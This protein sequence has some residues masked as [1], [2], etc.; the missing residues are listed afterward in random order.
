MGSR[1]NIRVLIIGLLGILFTFQTALAQ[2][3]KFG[4]GFFI[5]IF[6]HSG[7]AMTV[8]NGNKQSGIQLSQSVFTHG[9]NQQFAV[10]DLHQGNKYRIVARHS[11]LLLTHDNGRITQAPANGTSNQKFFIYG[12]N[13]T[14]YTIQCADGSKKYLQINERTLNDGDPVTTAL[15]KQKFKIEIEESHSSEKTLNES[16]NKGYYSLIPHHSS[17]K[18]EIPN[19]SKSR[20]IQVVQQNNTFNINQQFI[21]IDLHDGKNSYKIQVRHSKMYLTNEYGRITQQPSWGNNEQKFKISSVGEGLYTIQSLVDFSYFDVINGSKDNGAVLNCKAFNGDNNQKFKIKFEEKFTVRKSGTNA[22]TS[23]SGKEA[24]ID[25]SSKYFVFL[26]SELTRKLINWDKKITLSKESKYYAYSNKEINERYYLGGASVNWYAEYVTKEKKDIYIRDKSNDWFWTC[27]DNKLVLKPKNDNLDQKFNITILKSLRYR[28]RNAGY[29][30]LIQVAGKD[31]FAT[32]ELNEETN[33]QEFFFQKRDA[34]QKQEF[35]LGIVGGR[36][37]KERA[38]WSDKKYVIFSKFHNQNIDVTGD[39]VVRKKVTNYES[40][41]WSFKYINKFEDKVYIMHQSSKKY[42][43]TTKDGKNLILKPDIGS[44]RQHFTLRKQEDGSFKF[45][46]KNSVIQTGYDK[47]GSWV[48]T[49]KPSEGKTWNTFLIRDDYIQFVPEKDT[50]VGPIFSA[51][52][53][54]VDVGE[55][56]RIVMN[57]KDKPQDKDNWYFIRTSEAD[58]GAG[59]GQGS[60]RIMKVTTNQFLTYTP[61]KLLLSDPAK[62]KEWSGSGRVDITRTGTGRYTIKIYTGGINPKA[63][64]HGEVI[65]HKGIPYH[66]KIPA[67]CTPKPLWKN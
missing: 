46:T 4:S 64:V 65:N 26:N 43:T 34:S 28:E 57:C 29:N 18:L 67:L 59:P 40:Q 21:F 22:S 45:Y 58:K 27:V 53:C 9:Y 12:D 36:K 30:C 10:I 51:N 17:K 1:F 56:N 42:L 23:L 54:F 8:P 5:I 20:G 55:K 60:F 14:G 52:G 3:S 33:K 25:W 7:K 13:S 24:K 31:M 39:K 38:Y 15:L 66:W 35:R 49:G 32:I 44:S 50:V 19:S 2:K 41:M 6:T 61:S 63:E 47:G 16:L 11:E 48:G 62:H 37:R